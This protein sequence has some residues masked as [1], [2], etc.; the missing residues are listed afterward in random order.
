MNLKPIKITSLA[1]ICL[2]ALVLLGIAGAVSPAFAVGELSINAG[3]K[4]TNYHQVKLS[5]TPPAGSTRMRFINEG[6][7]PSAFE[8]VAV[9]RD[10]V[11]SAGDGD[12]NVTVQF[13]DDSGIPTGTGFATIKLGYILDRSFFNDGY[14]GQAK[15][16]G[17]KN[18]TAGQAVA[19][20]SDQK[21]VV[22]GTVD[23]GNGNSNMEVIRYLPDGTP[24]PDFARISST[25]YGAVDFPGHAVTGAHTGKAV[26]IDYLGRIVVVGTYDNGAG[27]TDL[28]VMRLNPDGTP[29]D[30]F[31]G[32]PLNG[33]GTLK[34]SSSSNGGADS[35][36]AVAIDSWDRIVVVG[37]Y[38]KGGNGTT[39]WVM[40]LDGTDGSL[41]PDFGSTGSGSVT[42]EAAIG[43]H[44]GNAVAIDGND[45]IV[46]VGTYDNGNGNTSVW[47]LRFDD[48]GEL[49]LIFG[50][51]GTGEDTYGAF[52][53]NKGTAVAINPVTGTISVLGTNYLNSVNTDVW[54]LQLDADGI[55]DATFNSTGSIALGGIGSGLDTGGAVAID[56]LGRIVVVGTYDNIG[57]TSL[58]VQRL[59]ADGSFDTT[60]NNGNSAYA[61]G[62]SGRFTGTAVALQADE[63]IVVAGMGDSLTGTSTI[64]TVRLHGFTWPL[65]VSIAGSGTVGVNLGALNFTGITGVGTYV[66]N[67]QV[68]LTATPLN[69]AAFAGW[70]GAC[71]GIADPV[72]TV[73]MDQAQ[74]VTATFTEIY[75]LLVSVTGVGTVTSAPGSI[76][77]TGTS[78]PGCLD[79]FLAGTPV[80][81]TATRPWYVLNGLWS[82]GT[83][84]GSI[85]TPCTFT[86]NQGRTVTATFIS[87]PNARVVGWGDYPTL[88]Q[89]YSVAHD[90]GPT[91]IIQAK[92]SAQ[93][94]FQEAPLNFNLP[95]IV[96]LQGGKGSDFSAP[97]V[98]FTSVIG[99]LNISNGRLNAGNLKIR[100]P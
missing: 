75:P 25:V 100:Q 67:T 11:L 34:F 16:A 4:S 64:Q 89:A 80:T 13:Q 14:R 91:A 77:C 97:A 99:P 82:G 47:T 35:G 28:W 70:D 38:D 86:M 73:T 93:V 3:A 44:T 81:L 62:Q 52:G 88:S 69:G 22:V 58:L 8:P 94:V 19:V 60:F 32:G 2:C 6:G 20:Q 17:T 26:A 31:T 27:D 33:V 36:S 23:L 9:T 66:P 71:A 65:T 83:C 53:A 78:G 98:G 43:L 95:L 12:K 42:V 50:S 54:L 29:D 15:V 18:I 84:S 10:W 30:T 39:P 41:D 92:D 74:S 55:L 90:S 49:D 51:R 37:T 59:N 57:T 45:Y 48:F 72:C 24:D 1:A 5:I 61:F 87:S 56:S 68:Q 63:K 76:A 7:A 46:V 21:I 79:I 96:T 85:T 40:R